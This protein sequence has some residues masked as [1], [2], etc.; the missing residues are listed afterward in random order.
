MARASRVRYWYS[1]L[2]TSTEH[3]ECIA[4]ASATLPSKTTDLAA[5]SDADPS[6]AGRILSS[7]PDS[8]VVACELSR[9]SSVA[10]SRLDWSAAAAPNSP[11]AKRKQWTACKWQKIQQKHSHC[12]RNLALW[13]GNNTHCRHLSQRETGTV[14]CPNAG[15]SFWQLRIAI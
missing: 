14:H 9:P 5:H 15:K 7:M 4:T 3:C 1:S 10:K 13:M 12:R 8:M 6:V 11:G 2:M